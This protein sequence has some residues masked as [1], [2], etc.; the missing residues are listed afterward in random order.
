VVA[1]IVGPPSKVPVLLDARKTPATAK[2][3]TGDPPMAN[4]EVEPKP[5]KDDEPLGPS[6]EAETWPMPDEKAK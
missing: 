2:P 5:D 3:R 6:P 4:P 1:V